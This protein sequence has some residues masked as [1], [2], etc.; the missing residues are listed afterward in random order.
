MSKDSLITKNNKRTYV[1]WNIKGRNPRYLFDYIK[2]IFSSYIASFIFV[3]AYALILCISLMFA[4][5]QIALRILLLLSLDINFIWLWLNFLP[6][7]LS[8][9]SND[10][11]DWYRKVCESTLL[12]LFSFE[13][14]RKCFEWYRNWFNVFLLAIY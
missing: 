7:L 2:T 13:C 12:S 8:F 9:A 1:D 6:E 5:I 14:Y 4:M 3:L 10:E 11:N